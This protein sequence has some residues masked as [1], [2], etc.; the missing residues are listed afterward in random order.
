MGIAVA[1]DLPPGTLAELLLHCDAA[2]RQ[3]KRSGVGVRLMLAPD[4]HLPRAA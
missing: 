3:A 1:T 4:H 2:L